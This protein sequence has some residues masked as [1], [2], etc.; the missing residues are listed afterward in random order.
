MQSSG[1]PSQWWGQKQY[2]SLSLA[3]M[4]V[5]PFKFFFS[6]GFFHVRLLTDLGKRAL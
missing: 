5:T 2:I 6:L 4:E 1:V 3:F